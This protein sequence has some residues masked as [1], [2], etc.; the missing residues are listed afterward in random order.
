MICWLCRHGKD[1]DTLRGGWSR[2]PLTAEGVLQAAALADRVAEQN[3]PI[4]HIYSSDLPRALQTAQPVAALL[5][6]P[7]T[8]LPEFREVNNGALAGMKNELAAQL[9]PGLYW[10]TLGWEEE[11]PQGESPHA[12]YERIAQA[13]AAFQQTI[14]AQSKDVLL[15]THSGVLHVILSL[16]NGEA[17]S[18]RTPHQRIP[19]AGLIALAHVEG[20]EGPW[21][22]ID[23]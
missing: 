22:L 17:Y 4:R 16:I 7:I 14:L 21:K 5:G 1:D 2:Q 8:P 13:W 15:V 19:Y 6:L 12:F 10:N 23:T 3:L 20:G 9:Y 11:Y 18:N